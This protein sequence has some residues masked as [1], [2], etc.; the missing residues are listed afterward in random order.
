[1][2]RLRN[3]LLFV[4]VGGTILAAIAVAVVMFAAGSVQKGEPTSTPTQTPTLTATATG[5]PTPTFTYTPTPT[6][7]PTSTPTPRPLTIVV[8]LPGVGTQLV[9]NGLT[10]AGPPTFEDI[11]PAIMAQSRR[12]VEFVFYSYAG[13]TVQPDG[14]PWP[15]SYSCPDT[16]QDPRVSAQRLDS[17]LDSLDSYE[18]RQGFDVQF[19]LIGHSLGGLV[20]VLGMQHAD[21]KAVV[22]LDSPLMGIGSVEA[23]GYDL[24]PSTCKG[25]AI[26]QLVTMRDDSTWPQT[27]EQRVTSFKAQGGRIATFGNADDCLY[28][29]IECPLWCGF[30]LC[31]FIA[32]EAD[33]Q[34]IPNADQEFLWSLGSNDGNGHDAILHA[35]GVATFIMAFVLTA[36]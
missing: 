18:R 28:N 16:V 3:P 29:P 1:M 8:L 12:P 20:A 9:S 7:T 33:T 26:E 23:T 17:Y 27:Q 11:E 25:P 31:P 2:A 13:F 34:I 22:T 4:P 36:P 35:S 19:V 6:S 10:A 5:T 24:W 32:D 21:V 30:V 15:L 14:R